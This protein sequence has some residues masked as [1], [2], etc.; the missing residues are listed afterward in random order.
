MTYSLYKWTK[1]LLLFLFFLFFILPLF[2]II[3]VFICSFFSSIDWSN[4]PYILAA[5]GSDGSSGSPS[6]L[7]GPNDFKLYL[8][9]I[10]CPYNTYDTDKLADFMLQGFR[11]EVWNVNGFNRVV[12]VPISLSDMG[13]PGNISP[14]TGKN[15]AF[16]SNVF[17]YI[18]QNGHIQLDVN[19][20]I[21][22]SMIHAVR[23][24]RLNVPR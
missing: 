8:N 2:Y 14:I 21:N 12:D 10:L 1:Y 3:V 6:N 23:D 18:T 20:Q 22:R 9:H 15:I 11:T 5:S 24:L 7:P 16:E 4:I 13:I 19:S 17:R